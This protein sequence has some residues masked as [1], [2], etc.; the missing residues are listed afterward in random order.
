MVTKRENGKETLMKSRDICLLDLK[1]QRKTVETHFVSFE[2]NS[3]LEPFAEKSIP[4]PLKHE[5]ERNKGLSPRRLIPNN[6]STSQVPVRQYYH[7]RT[8]QPIT[9]MEEWDE[10][11]DDEYDQ[12]WMKE[13]GERVRYLV[14]T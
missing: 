1:Q 5:L 2:K 9:R 13:L 6:R 8:N 10:D 7:S 12:E 14:Y 11:S 3:F 4:K